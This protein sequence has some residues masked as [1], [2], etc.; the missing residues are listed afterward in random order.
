MRIGEPRDST[1]LVNCADEPIHMPG[2][3]QP[4]GA[5]LVFSSTMGLVAWSNNVPALLGLKVSY[6]LC[7]ALL[8]FPAHV[9]ELIVL[10]HAELLQGHTRTRHLEVT[11]G[12]AIHDCVVHGYQHRIYVEFEV[13]ALASHT[14]ADAGLSSHQRIDRFRRKQS[15]HE[16]LALAVRHV[17]QLTGFDRVMAY[18]FRHDDSGDVVAED[19]ADDM[20]PYLGM[21][22]PASD[23]PAQARRLYIVSTLR[24]IPDIGYEPV[25][26]LGR[27]G[28]LAV[29]MSHCT[30]RSVSPIH[31]EYLQNMGVAASMSISIVV[32]GRLWGL[33]A[34]H[35]RAPRLVPYAM[36]KAIDRLAHV[37]ASTAS[38][39]EMAARSQRLAEAA[40]LLQR[41]SN[42]MVRPADLM[43][44]LVSHSA[45]LCKLMQAQAMVM[46]VDGHIH[47]HGTILPV[48]AQAIVSSKE[49]ANLDMV[50]RSDCS[51]W[52][53]MTSD[54]SAAWP[55]MLGFCFDTALN[56]WAFFL[57]EDQRETVRWGGNPTPIKTTGALGPRLTP[58]GSFEEWKQTV[59][60]TALP[61]DITELA[62][63][64]QLA[65]LL[66]RKSAIHHTE[67]GRA[68]SELLAMLAHDLRTPLQSISTAAS[69]M[70]RQNEKLDLARRILA[71]SNR[72]ARLISQVLDMSR[73]GG[74]LA[75]GLEPND[76]DLAALIRDAA[77]EAGFANPAMRYQFEFDGELLCRVDADRISQVVGNL[78]GNAAAHCEQGHAVTITLEATQSHAVISVRNK[79]LPIAPEIVATLFDP[80]KNT[81]P[82]SHQNRQGLGLGL[83]IVDAVVAAHG[84]TVGYDH[85]Q[86]EVVFSV[87]L[88]LARS[89]CR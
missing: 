72:M 33:I 54:V 81:S 89:L 19:C 21:R 86:S 83:Y 82:A 15:I 30:L 39:L 56:G 10:A 79:A 4:H 35:H 38:Q 32:D 41:V 44:A 26:M 3:I 28:D 88:P 5:M 80:F 65:G 45:E 27:I 68:R 46:C 13:R 48:H 6:G 23:I 40:A 24:I 85:V 71:S 12:D 76:H 18:R 59:L 34:C 31:I 2:F 7:Y 63:A 42:A 25:P 20:T 8:E 52:P 62:I 75:L 55:G 9:K 49:N 16:M 69:I 17:R 74:G 14:V 1:S 70:V 66:H 64:E 36:R 43:E 29:D 22:Y 57:R 77:S 84:G 58:R 67:T 51:H 73:L 87:K 53:V 50:N 60:G 37:L 78:L 47:S 11:I 61:W